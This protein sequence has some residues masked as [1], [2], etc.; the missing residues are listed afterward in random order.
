METE[1]SHERTAVQKRLEERHAAGLRDMESKHANLLNK[2]KEASAIAAAE[3]EAAVTEATRKMEARIAELGQRLEHG[4][5]V[6][7]A[8]VPRLQRSFYKNMLHYLL[9][10]LQL[11]AGGTV[12]QGAARGEVER[13]S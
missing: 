8:G 5:Q 4:D 12:C 6:R 3:A 7:L 9:T 11:P 2:H 10:L 13:S 1:H